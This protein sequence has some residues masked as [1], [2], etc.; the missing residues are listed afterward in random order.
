MRSKQPQSN[1]IQGYQGSIGQQSQ[2]Q[3]VGDWRCVICC[4]VNF[5]FRT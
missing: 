4:N 2:Q 5:A 1:V 3:R